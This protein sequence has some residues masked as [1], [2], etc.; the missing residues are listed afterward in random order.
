[1]D[2]PR[3]LASRIRALFTQPSLATMSRVGSLTQNI[4]TP[5]PKNSETRGGRVRCGGRTETDGDPA[6]FQIVQQTEDEGW[7]PFGYRWNQAR[8]GRSGSNAAPCRNDRPKLLV[9]GQSIQSTAP[10]GVLAWRPRLRNSSQNS[11]SPSPLMELLS[12]GRM[13]HSLAWV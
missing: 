13:P 4:A 10:G 9:R 8:K 7:P 5:A 3:L 1:M 11:L 6:R 12:P 2:V